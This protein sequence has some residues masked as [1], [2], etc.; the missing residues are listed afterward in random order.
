MYIAFIGIPLIEEMPEGPEIKVSEDE[1]RPR[2]VGNT[3]TNISWTERAKQKNLD[4]VK[5]PIKIIGTG[6]HGK[7][8]F[9]YLESQQVI[10][11]SYGMTGRLVW[12]QGNHSYINFTLNF[13]VHQDKLILNKKQVLYFDDSR[14]FGSVECLSWDSFPHYLSRL[15]PDLLANVIP[16]DDWRQIFR[17]KKLQNKQICQVL[18]DQAIIS[19]VGNYIKAEVLYYSKIKPD[20]IIQ[21]LADQELETLRQVTHWVIRQSYKYGGLTLRDFISPSGNPGVFPVAIYGKSH[22][23][24][25]YTVVKQKFKDTRTTHWVP[26]IQV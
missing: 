4:Q 25:G 9:F 19:G 18:L 21:S 16:S 1:L 2:I 24:N 22:D 5:T 20:R 12:N 3:I 26:E 8:M 10:I 15:G 14:H 23:P 7:K 6:T 13:K 11:F 17:Q